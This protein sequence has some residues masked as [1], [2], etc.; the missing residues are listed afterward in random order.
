VA[1]RIGYIHPRGCASQG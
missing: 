1:A